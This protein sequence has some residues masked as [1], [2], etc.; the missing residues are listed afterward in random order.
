MT[1][2]CGFFFG[3]KAA[4]EDGAMQLG[5]AKQHN[6]YIGEGGITLANT[7]DD[8]MGG[9]AGVWTVT[10]IAFAE[11]PPEATVTMIFASGMLSG[12]AACNIYEAEVGIED[13]R[14]NLGQMELGSEECDT[15]LMETEVNF[16]RVLERSNRF[17]ISADGTLTLFA[18]DF[19]MLK[20][21]R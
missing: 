15:E 12:L 7:Q 8:T 3:E 13:G 4:Q 19:M 21:R 18:L 16:L 5:H 20:A 17:E 14:L 2:S 9:L 1:L 6:L 10:E 11:L